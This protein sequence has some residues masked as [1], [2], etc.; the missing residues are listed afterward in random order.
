MTCEIDRPIQST[1]SDTINENL[2]SSFPENLFHLGQSVGSA[3][4]KFLSTF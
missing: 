3:P 1:A 4:R 2:Y